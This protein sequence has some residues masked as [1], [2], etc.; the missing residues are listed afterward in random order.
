MSRYVVL[1]LLGILLLPCLG[2]TDTKPLKPVVLQLKWDP[3]FQFAGFYAALWQGYYRDVG[4]DVKI[5]PR[6]LPNGQLLN[7][8]DEVESGRAQFGIGGPDILLDQDKGRDFVVLGTLFQKTPHAYFALKNGPIQTLEDFSQARIATS[9]DFGLIELL[10]LAKIKGITLKEE[11]WVEYEFGLEPLTRGTADVVLDYAVSGRWAARRK[12]LEVKEF[13]SKNHGLNSYGDLVFTTGSFAKKNSLLVSDFWGATVLGWQHALSHEVDM[14]RRLAALPR[15]FSYEDPLSYNLHE[16][17]T[18]RNLMN[19]P[20]TPVGETTQDGWGKLHQ[21]LKELGLVVNAFDFD[22]FY[23]DYR[24]HQRKEQHIQK[25]QV[26]SV[27]SVLLGIL[28]CGVLYQY[29]KRSR[30]RRQ[31]YERIVE[32]ESRLKYAFEAANEG[33]WEL[34]DSGM[35]Y[36]S[37]GGYKLLGY[38][39]TDFE[40]SVSV[41]CSMVHPDDLVVAE[42]FFNYCKQASANECFQAEYR[43]KTS[44]GDHRWVLSKAKKIAD[45]YGLADVKVVG[46]F[47]DV[48]D[49]KKIEHRL[50]ELNLELES[51][52]KER[53][54]A[55]MKITDQL[56]ISESKLKEVLNAI[57]L[58]IAWKNNDLRYSGCNQRFLFDLG[59]SDSEGVIGKT[60]E[61]LKWV[62]E[63]IEFEKSDFESLE[64]K[65]TAL[66]NVEVR[67][68]QEVDYFRIFKAPFRFTDNKNE[69]GVLMVCENITDQKRIED[70]NSYN[71]N[72]LKSILEASS[73]HI[74]IVEY[75]DGKGIFL[76]A[77]PSLVHWSRSSASSVEGMALVDIYGSHLTAVL[78]VLDRKI[79]EGAGEHQID[80]WMKNT[81]GIKS[82]FNVLKTAFHDRSGKVVGVLSVARDITDKRATEMIHQTFYEHSTEPHVLLKGL[83]ILY[84][85]RAFA[86]ALGLGAAENVKNVDISKFFADAEPMRIQ[87]YLAQQAMVKD[88]GM[89]RFE[90]R[91]R[92]PDRGLC[93]YEVTQVAVDYLDDV[94]IMEVWHD[95]EDRVRQARELINAKKSAEESAD[96]KSRFLAN[97]S[98]EIRTP[99]NAILG[100]S[101]VALRKNLDDTT[102]KY[103]KRIN[104]ASASLLAILND[105][106]D[107]SKLEAKAL[108]IRYEPVNVREFMAI[109]MALFEERAKVKKLEL[110]LEVGE[111]V[112][113]CLDF[114][115][116]RVRQI[117]TNLV[118]NAIKFTEVGEVKIVAQYIEKKFKISVIDS[119]IGMNQEQMQRLFQPYY[120]AD[121]SITRRY[122][123][124]GLGLTISKQLSEKM[125]GDLFVESVAGEGS[126][127]VVTI[128][129]EQ[130]QTRIAQV[131]HDEEPLLNFSSS[132][133]LVA[134]DNLLN[135]ELI[136]EVLSEF[137]ATVSIVNNGQ[138]AINALLNE[139]FD[140]VFMDVQMPVMDGIKAAKQIRVSGKSVPIVAMTANVLDEDRKQCMEAGMS[141][142]LSKPIRIR[143]VQA[144]LRKWLT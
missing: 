93:T 132:K 28:L 135:Q 8:S 136:Q 3:E 122:G 44:D 64:G 125:S 115:P 57:P 87:A 89:Q 102:R 107:F 17:E 53:T 109:I 101:Q 42:K 62:C 84:A 41:L 47:T 73:D 39:S 95:V 27:L 68:K 106:L 129:A 26:L 111:E 128:P 143:E 74:S 60:D 131:D 121:D 92:H 140:L 12:K 45:L 58:G 71:L 81:S 114:D 90:W 59:L 124:T 85:N 51:R 127:F 78:E 98:H 22:R 79:L 52:V 23:F 2:L 49:Q 33:V 118:G 110:H 75:V 116:T 21:H 67:V 4:L 65:F 139:S 16:A 54:R 63:A 56:K 97:M 134:E 123:G 142:Y 25:L 141:D 66:S 88:H 29:A 1:T 10:A 6:P 9:R 119:G 43:F 105:I 130:S 83:K 55:F 77:N 133:I 35:F 113:D 82:L 46:T 138:E 5:V 100:F 117:V 11:R 103:L 94:A 24:R 61:E 36:L 86:C 18:V 144:K 120:Q 80:L 19:Y 32:N 112:P 40:A 91:Y 76:L 38:E 7:V 30:I 96:S 69:D 13:S 137:G 34:S 50:A 31:E 99:M 72:L 104:E 37:P 48:S 20:V 15:V 108:Q 14:A 70:Q 126:R